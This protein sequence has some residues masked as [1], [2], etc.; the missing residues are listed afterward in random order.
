M[1][2]FS[3]REIDLINEVKERKIYKTVSLLGTLLSQKNAFLINEQI[4]E[5]KKKAT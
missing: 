2:L 4:L 1:Q 3:F 5:K